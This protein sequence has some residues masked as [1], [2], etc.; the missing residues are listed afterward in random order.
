MPTV[1][2][3]P[4]ASGL[5]AE[6]LT[7]VQLMMKS[8]GALRDVLRALEALAPRSDAD[9]AAF[10]DFRAKAQAARRVLEDVDA[11]LAAAASNSAAATQVIPS[12]N[13]SGGSDVH[14]HVH[15]T[16]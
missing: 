12:S 9:R 4:K 8:H 2:P 13:G 11:E 15:L 1:D 5:G 10:D 16:R 3:D 7:P 14:I 6:A